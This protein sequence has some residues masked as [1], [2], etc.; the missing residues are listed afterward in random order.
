LA[1]TTAGGT[2]TPIQ[3]LVVIYDENISFDHYFATYPNALN[4]EGEP[5]F[6]PSA[7][8]PNVNG[9]TPGLLQMNQNPAPP[10][11]PTAANFSPAI[12]TITTPMNKPRTMVGSSTRLR[13]R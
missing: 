6:T 8:T 11:R 7:T 2:V 9:L 10:I 5:V 4:P 13:R 3:H 12:T 1:Q